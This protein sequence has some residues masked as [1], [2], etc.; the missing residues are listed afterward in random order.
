MVLSDIAIH[1]P[2]LATVM[3][4]VLVIFGIF[5]YRQLSVREYP[6]IDPPVVSISTTYRGAAAEI[7]ESQITQVI[8]DAVAGIEGIRSIDSSSREESSSISIEFALSRD[9]ES[10]AN[11]IRD[12]VARIANRL[13]A[14]A[15]APTVAKTE[16]DS[17]PILWLTLTSA[18]LSALELTDYAERF[19][20]DRF[21]TVPGVASVTISGGRRY[22]MRVDVHR[23]ALAARRLTVQD[24]EDAIRRQNVDLPSGRIEGSMREFTV[25]T[26]SGMRTPQEFR[27]LVVRETEGF[28][29]R[30][31]EVATVTLGAASERN[32]LRANGRPSIGLGIIRQSKANTLEVANGVKALLPLLR[33]TLPE[34]VTLDVS[35]DTSIFIASSIKEVYISL[36]IAVVLVIGIIYVFLRSWRATLIPAMAI[37]VS[38]IAS[39]ILID[40]LG[41]SIN[42]LTLLAMV[43]AIG[44]VVDDA[45]VVMENVHRRIE[46]GEPPL[47]AALRGSRQIGFAVISTTVVLIAV[48]VPLSFLGG[49]IGRLFREFGISIAATLFFSGF[50]ALTLTPMMCSRLMR[51]PGQE[52]R[53]YRATQFIFDGM[54]SG[55]RRLLRRALEM[56]R[57]VVAGA[58]VA[59]VLGGVFF[60]VLPREFVPT[61]DRGGVFVSISGPEGASMDYTRRYVIEIERLLAPMVEEKLADRVLMILAPGFSRPGAVNSAFGIVRLKPWDQRDVSQQELVA[62]LMPQLVA[63]PGVRAFASNPPGLGQRGFNA[64]VQFVLGG[65]TYAVLDQWADRLIERAAEN[66]K[67]IN[68]NKDYQE[69]RPEIRV[70]IDRNRAA[71]LGVPVDILART[72]ETML[73]SRQVTTFDRDGKQYDVIVQ[74]TAGDRAQPTDLSN[75]YVRAPRSDRLVPLT[76]LVTLTET[77]GARDLGRVNRLRAI[78]ITASLAPGYTLGAALEYL[79]QLADAELPAEARISFSGESR[80]FRESSA[81]L[82]FVFALALLVVFLTLAG[83][84]ESFLHASIIMISVPLAVTGALASMLLTGLSLN[85]YSQIGII[86]LVGLIAKN[87]IL[88]VDFANQLRDDGKTVFDAVLE[89]AAARLRP[90]LMTT[91]STMLG[92]VPLAF[93]TGA[94]AESR[95]PLGIVVIG[96]MA[97]S[98]VLSLFVVPAMY[99]LI[100]PYT[101]PV[102]LIARRLSDLE[103]KFPYQAVRTGE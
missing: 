4:M 61:E 92:L 101:K 34:G 56:P 80:E 19:L 18:R 57:L 83:Q 82:Y 20:T 6:D 74:A 66:P 28:L 11:D 1:R 42:V 71:D 13:P 86:M 37:P 2:A 38:I 8:E 16:A 52:S 58:A 60:R 55:F 102:G 15:D 73:G 103:K 45:I 76:N 33:N 84:F 100:A 79:E 25:R 14:E 48:F 69:S 5:S 43:I 36:A 10:A 94:G 9:I 65:P 99:L 68:V 95:Q 27:N 88:I 64:P 49:N 77:A 40:A 22:A 98:T 78:T 72:L 46:E 70:R 62:K 31:G 24:V 26:D 96:G 85:V 41:Y 32:E 81:A 29:T 21:S 91:L 30:L 39:F 12:R 67:L 97:F 93:A 89:A 54:S 63:I 7:V 44:I 51:E 47:L 59:A 3:S 87:A 75:I 53:F 17:R 23:A 90:I 50:V 35:Y